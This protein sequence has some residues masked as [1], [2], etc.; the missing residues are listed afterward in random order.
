MNHFAKIRSALASG[1]LDA[2]VLWRRPNRF[3][4]SG[5]DS[6]GSADGMC[7]ITADETY[8]WTD[9]R[10]IEAA[11]S[12]VKDAVIGLV[13]REHTYEDLLGE[14]AKRH[15]LHTVGYEEADLTVADF[16]RLEKTLPESRLVPASKLMTTL[17][18][19]KDAEELARMRRAQEIAESA[20]QEV[21]NDI[22]PGVS[23]RFLAARFIFLMRCAGAENVSFDP[24]TISGKNTSL[25]HGVPSDKLVEDGDFVTMDFGAL[26]QGYCS[27]TTRTVAV[28]HATDEMQ[29]VYNIVLEAQK[30]GIAAAKAGVTG[31]AVDGAARAV[32]EK[33]GYGPA[34]SHGFG[35][36]VGVEIHENPNANFGN[37]D[38]L[39]AGAVISAE[40]GIYLAG[41]FGVRIEDVVIIGE[42]G[43]EDITRAPK[44]LMIL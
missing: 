12:Q 4:A 21:L 24:I 15:N 27:D 29:K 33:A 42:G 13:D 20:L 37:P 16:R 8:Y 40:P 26:Y 36:G 25:P 43:C 3:Y 30:A 17:R 2:I 39:P 44:E 34:F 38:P 32:I 1:G 23:E 10:Y 41:R 35:H 5:F 28:G 31:V 9:G 6:L 11:H 19:V 14:A 7:L 18:S 22:R